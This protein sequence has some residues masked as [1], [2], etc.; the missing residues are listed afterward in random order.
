MSA[1]AVIDLE[2]FRQQR[3]EKAQPAT[4]RF[5]WQPVWVWYW[6]PVR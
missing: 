4:P 2:S 1:A 5:T 6:M 3:R